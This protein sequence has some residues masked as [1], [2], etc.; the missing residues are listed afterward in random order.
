MQ[1]TGYKKHIASS[2]ETF[3]ILALKYYSDEFT[4]SYIIECNPEY[5]NVLIFTG[6]EILAIPV[7]DTLEN[8][9]TL[10]PWRR[11]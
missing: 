3:D 11:T 6:G 8:D 9:L 2:G 5:S 10:A 7:F 4:S 1:V